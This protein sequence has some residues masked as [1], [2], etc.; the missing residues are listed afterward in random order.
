MKRNFKKESRSKSS[1][2]GIIIFSS[3]LFISATIFIFNIDKNSINNIQ[4]TSSKLNNLLRKNDNIEPYKSHN[5]EKIENS[6][7]DKFIEEMKKEYHQP[8]HII[9]PHQSSRYAYV[10]LISGIDTSFK[11][12]GF[13]YNAIIIKKS[14]NDLNSKADFVALIGYSVNDT[15]PFESDMELLRSHG[16]ILYILPR[17]IDASHSLSFAEMAL[18]KITPYSFIQ[19]ERIQFFDGDVMPTKDMDCFFK[20][21]KNTFTVGAVSPLNS[22][23]YLGLPNMDDYNYFKK[24]AIWRLG[25]DWDSENGWGVSMP[26]VIIRIILYKYIYS[27]NYYFT[28]V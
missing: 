8:S 16:I 22:G 11:Y 12:R 25:R 17:L 23:W 28:R 24:M 9:T 1:Y 15:T 18:L 20:L 13:L 4:F 7:S 2:L 27:N 3:L 26:K 14:L 19:Y 6:G 5:Y 21:D 10:T